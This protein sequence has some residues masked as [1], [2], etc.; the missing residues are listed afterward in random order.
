MAVRLSPMVLPM[1]PLLAVPLQVV[2]VPV[3]VRRA[4]LAKQLW[5]ERAELLALLKVTLMEGRQMKRSLMPLGLLL[6]ALL[7]SVELVL[8]TALFVQVVA[9][10]WLL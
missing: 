3:L 2:K 7:E 6:L 1:A 9:L 4:V 8:V 10:K 5:L